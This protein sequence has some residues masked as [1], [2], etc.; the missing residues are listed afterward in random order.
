MTR[1]ICDMGGPTRTDLG[2]VVSVFVGA[3]VAGVLFLWLTVPLDSL[4]APTSFTVV[5]IVALGAVFLVYLAVRRPLAEALEKSDSPIA[6]LIRTR[7]NL[8]LAVRVVAL[9]VF[10][11]GAS[12]FVFWAA[13]D[14]LGGYHGYDYSFAYYPT[15]LQIYNDSVGLIPYV[16]ARDKGTQAS[17]YLVIAFLGLVALRANRGLGEAIRDAITVFIAPTTVIFELALWSQAPEDMTWHA[18]DFLW[19]GGIDDSGFRARDFVQAP[20]GI[21]PPGPDQQYLGVYASGPY[22]FSNWFVLFAALFLVASRIP[23]LS[24]PSVLQWR[25]KDRGLDKPS[26]AST[27]PG[28][29]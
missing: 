2:S 29:D 28:S 16:S 7:V 25:R 22:I 26:T 17:I 4:A 3:A 12:F 15:L 21:Y 11:L 13:A 18:T 23:W 24:L 8:S 19:V 5:E 1:E 10:V 20:L 9:A 27:S 6:R 14:V